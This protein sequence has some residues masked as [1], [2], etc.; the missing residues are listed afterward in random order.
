M[1][2]VDSRRLRKKEYALPAAEL[3]ASCTHIPFVEG[4]A[5]EK[6]HVVALQVDP[7]ILG[8]TVFIIPLY[9]VPNIHTLQGYTCGGT[10]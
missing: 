4:T 9:S 3:I 10:P 5:N 1:I 8:S 7:S 6:L 2:A